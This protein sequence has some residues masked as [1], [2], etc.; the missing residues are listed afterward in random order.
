VPFDPEQRSPEQDLQQILEAARWAPTAHNMQNF[1]LIVIDDKADLAVIGAIRSEPSSTFLRE[2]YQQLAFSE[3]ELLR[4]K[5]G[6]LASM[7][8]PSWQTLDAKP[9]RDA[10][11]PHAISRPPC[12][13]VPDAV[14]R[15]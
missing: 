14:G 9:E 10:D 12:A 4:K 3:E 1:E 13:E 8:A 7:F 5:T 6:L 11:G 15:L 2:N